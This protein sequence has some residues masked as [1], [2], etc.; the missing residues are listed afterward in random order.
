MVKTYGCTIHEVLYD[1]SFTNLIM[2][3]AVLPSYNKSSKGLK[4]EDI[5][6]ASDPNNKEAVHKIMFGE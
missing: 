1:L 2:Y 5:I 4:Q 6:N 3:N